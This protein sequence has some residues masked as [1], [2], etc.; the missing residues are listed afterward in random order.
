VSEWVAQV[1]HQRVEVLGQAL[2][3][4]G[5][6]FFVELVGQRLEPAFGVLL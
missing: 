4:G 5:E 6:P 3:R 1:R 2:G